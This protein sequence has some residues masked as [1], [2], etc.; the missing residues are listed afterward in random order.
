M[1]VN[2]W[3]LWSDGAVRVNPAASKEPVMHHSLDK[4]KKD[5]HQGDYKQKPS[6]PERGWLSSFRGLRIRIR[7]HQICLSAGSVACHATTIHMIS[8][9][10]G[11]PVLP[12][13]LYRS[14]HEEFIWQL[15]P[16]MIRL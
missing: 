13:I 16:F 9:F 8:H 10:P 1:V 4:E 11:C 15:S 6:N 12:F 7:C 2:G 5:D 3:R 14:P